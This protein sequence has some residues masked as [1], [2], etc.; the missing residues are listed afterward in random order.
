MRTCLF[1]R[2]WKTDALLGG[3][4]KD[5]GS[6]GLSVN[7]TGSTVAD[8]PKQRCVAREASGAYLETHASFGC[9]QFQHR[10]PKGA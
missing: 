1:C 5:V 8:V 3:N 4:G 7:D 10:P 2:Y 9:N 6:C